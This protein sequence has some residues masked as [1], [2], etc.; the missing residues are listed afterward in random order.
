MLQLNDG[1]C[2]TDNTEVFQL[3]IKDISI[4]DARI[5][6]NWQH[7]MCFNWKNIYHNCQHK[8]CY[9]YL[10]ENREINQ[11]IK[12]VFSNNLGGMVG[13]SWVRTDLWLERSHGRFPLP[14]LLYAEKWILNN[15]CLFNCQKVNPASVLHFFDMESSNSSFQLTMNNWF[16]ISKKCNTDTWLYVMLLKTNFGNTKNG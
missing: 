12:V 9:S 4:M 14:A 16:H 6:R 3:K 13:A 7:L 10:V 1:S 5:E 11:A 8:Y 2:T 15:V